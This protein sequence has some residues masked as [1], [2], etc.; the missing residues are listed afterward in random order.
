LRLCSGEIS[1]NA[2][3]WPA[4]LYPDGHEYNLNWIELGLLRGEFFYAGMMPF[5]ILRLIL[6]VNPRY[7]D[8]FSHRRRPHSEKHQEEGEA[9]EA[10]P[11]SMD[12]KESC[13]AQSHMLLSKY[14]QY[15]IFAKVSKLTSFKAY[16]TISSIQTWTAQH[17]DFNL[18]TFY[19]NVVELFEMDPEAEWAVDTLAPVILS[20]HRAPA[21]MSSC[22]ELVIPRDS[23]REEYVTAPIP[24]GVVYPLTPAK[25][26][27]ELGLATPN[28][29]A[30]VGVALPHSIHALVLIWLD[31]NAWKDC[32]H[33][34]IRVCLD[35]GTREREELTLQIVCVL[36]TDFYP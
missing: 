12:S 26:Q 4:F 28:I 27:G 22:L 10:M 25:R 15:P 14:V 9:N 5:L 31:G 24:P 11:R 23:P 6:T 3:D 8:I 33:E 35:A 34:M 21:F 13:H 19:D 36:M 20:S 16:F 2:D 1:V 18:K 17:G 32:D 7:A 29:L 30:A